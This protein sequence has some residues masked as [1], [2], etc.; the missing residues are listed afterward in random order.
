[1]LARP[2][3]VPAYLSPRFNPDYVLMRAVFGL[4][5]SEK[6]VFCTS[7]ALPKRRA[8]RSAEE[9]EVGLIVVASFL[10]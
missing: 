2:L 3:A 8:P 9:V 4:F 6:R 1:M 5:P 10:T 7:L